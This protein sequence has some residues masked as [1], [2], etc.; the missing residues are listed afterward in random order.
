MSNMFGWNLNVGYSDA[1][2]APSIVQLIEAVGTNGDIAKAHI[3][4]DEKKHLKTVDEANANSIDFLG[5]LGK[6]LTDSKY[7]AMRTG[8]SLYFQ[9]SR[10]FHFEKSSEKAIV[11]YVRFCS[12]ERTNG[13]NEAFVIAVDALRKILPVLGEFEKSNGYFEGHCD[14]PIAFC[15]CFLEKLKS[16]YGAFQAL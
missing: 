16:A 15:E 12:F 13:G 8:V 11:Y 14:A 3:F 10:I 2:L 9:N 5:V 1:N 6:Y 4:Q 7:E